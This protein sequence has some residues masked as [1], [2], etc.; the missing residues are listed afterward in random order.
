MRSPRQRGLIGGISASD[1]D[2]LAAQP[3]ATTTSKHAFMLNIECDLKPEILEKKISQILVLQHYV[4]LAT[5]WQ[6]QYH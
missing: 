1:I 3:D 5:P 2:G 4:V 6:H